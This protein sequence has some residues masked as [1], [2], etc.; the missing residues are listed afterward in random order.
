MLSTVVAVF[1]EEEGLSAF[2]KELVFQ[3]SK[4]KV[5]FEVVFVDDGSTDSSFSILKKFEEKNK[6]VRI[7]SFRKNQGKAEALTL[8]FQ[9]ARGN[10]V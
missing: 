1:N 2:Y 5:R 9:K 7:F 4:L 3:A 8:G 10:S 6:N